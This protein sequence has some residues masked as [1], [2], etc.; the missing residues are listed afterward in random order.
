MGWPQR[1]GDSAEDFAAQQEKIRKE[2]R[3]KI[4]AYIDRGIQQIIDN[5][6]D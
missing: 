5:K 3:S 1:D 2:V 6:E 4:D